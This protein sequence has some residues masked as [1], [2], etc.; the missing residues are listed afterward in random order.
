M[1]LICVLSYGVQ[2]GK[3]NTRDAAAPRKRCFNPR[4][5][6]GQHMTIVEDTRNRVAIKT[7]I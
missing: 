7:T 4:M 6:A 1:S 3:E 5:K 2:R